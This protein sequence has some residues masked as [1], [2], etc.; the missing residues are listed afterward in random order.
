MFSSLDEAERQALAALAVE[1]RYEPGA[2]LFTEGDPCEGL[3]LIGEGVVKIVK[4]TASGR[5]IMLALESAPATVAE[6]PIFDGGS[7]PASVFAVRETTA[8][9]IAKADF[10]RVCRSHAEIPMKMLR[11]TGM[12]LRQLVMLV[13]AVTFGSVRQRLA[14]QLLEW[15]AAAGGEDFALPSSQEELAMRLGTVREVIS[16]NLSRFQAEGLLQIERRRIRILDAGGLRAEAES[17]L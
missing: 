17:E 2:V 7:Y 9:L 3:Y 12:R 6:V 14:S 5:E 1:R 15:H 16:R 11:V 8:F 13:Q 4:T 10:H